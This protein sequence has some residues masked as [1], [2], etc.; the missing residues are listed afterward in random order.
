MIWGVAGKRAIYRGSGFQ[1]LTLSKTLLNNSCLCRDK[2]V[3]TTGEWQKNK[4]QEAS[5]L[6]FALP[7]QKPTPTLVSSSLFPAGNLFRLFSQ[8]FSGSGVRGLDCPYKLYGN[9]YMAT[10][11]CSKTMNKRSHPDCFRTAKGPIGPETPKY[12]K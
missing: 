9:R 3:V 11:E 6:T 10:G 2:Y 7:F 1:P 8:L 5:L 4:Q 12:S